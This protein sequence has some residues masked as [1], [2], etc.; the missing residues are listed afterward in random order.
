MLVSL[1]SEEIDLTAIDRR[2][3]GK[4]SG[5]TARTPPA[6]G[7]ASRSKLACM[8]SET[9]DLFAPPPPEPAAARTSTPRPAPAP[10]SFALQAHCDGGAR[11]NPGPAGYGAE[12]RD[13]S[14]MVV[15]ELSEFLG[16]RTN[17]FAEYS[18]LLACLEYA[19]DHGAPSL[20]VV[21]DSKLMVMQIQGRYKISSPDLKP[22]WTEARARIARLDRFEIAHAL[23]HKNKAADRLANEAMDRGTKRPHAPGAP[24]PPP[25]AAT[26]YPQRAAAPA[27][28]AR[29]DPAP[30][31]PIKVS[32]PESY[33]AATAQPTP[34]DTPQAP[35]MLRGFSRDGVIHIL[36]GH[37]LPDGRFVKIIPE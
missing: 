11:G 35:P 5:Q 29:I 30:R 15:A 17:N 16:F 21:S 7:R 19:L 9:G 20:R 33:S 32:R 2:Q 4:V 22:L 31:P 27:T 34:A 37:T 24:S 18:G 1:R 8:P 26:P 6:A 12:I 28:P 14:G 23:R 25:L 36:G 13:A 3:P 10:D